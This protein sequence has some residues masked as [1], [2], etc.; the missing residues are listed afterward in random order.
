VSS[1]Q[2]KPLQYGLQGIS[3][4]S[5]LT[6]GT[7]NYK[8]NIRRLLKF[9]GIIILKIAN[10]VERDEVPHHI[11]SVYMNHDGFET[12]TWLIVPRLY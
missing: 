10:I 1:I 3:I 11:A 9:S 5:N 4:N 12:T 2:I 7:I 6:L 8:F